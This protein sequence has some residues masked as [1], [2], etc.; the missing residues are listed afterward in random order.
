MS[1]GACE[2]EDYH[3]Y[4][5]DEASGAAELLTTESDQEEELIRTEVDSFSPFILRA[6][7]YT[8]TFHTGGGTIGNL[9]DKE[10]KTGV[11]QTTLTGDELP[12]PEMHDSSV[13][14]AG[15][16]RD[17][18]YSGGSVTSS[19][20]GTFYAKYTRYWDRNSSAY[21][22][23]WYNEKNGTESS[24][25]GVRFNGYINNE[26]EQYQIIA[27]YGYDGMEGFIRNYDPYGGQEFALGEI[28]TVASGDIFAKY[29][30]SY[31]VIKDLYVAQVTTYEG[32][33]T[34]LSYYLWNKGTDKVKLNLGMMESMGL[35]DDH[36]LAVT[37]KTDGLGTY[38]CME[39][40]NL[41]NKLYYKGPYVTDT[42][43]V[44]LDDCD[45]NNYK[46]RPASSFISQKTSQP[47][48]D[49][50]NDTS[51]YLNWIGL[52]IPAGEV[53][54][55]SVLM[56]CNKKDVLQRSNY[57]DLQL[58]GLYGEEYA[59]GTGLQNEQ[60]EYGKEYTLPEAYH[61]DGYTFDGWKTMWEN[62]GRIYQPGEKI[63]AEHDLRT[64]ELRPIYTIIENTAKITIKKDGE[65]WGGHTVELH[66]TQSNLI[67]GMEET[68]PGVYVNNTVVNGTYN[69]WVDGENSQEQITM[70][71]TVLSIEKAASVGYYTAQVETTLD[72]VPHVITEEDVITLRKG[73][74]AKYT[75]NGDGGRYEQILRLTE[76]VQV[77]FNGADTGKVITASDPY[78]AIE[79]VTAEVRILDAEPWRDAAVELH[80]EN[81][82]TVGQLTYAETDP[83]THQ[84]Y[85]REIRKKD[86]QTSYKVFVNQ[87]DTHCTLTASEEGKNVSLV[88]YTATVTLEGDMADAA[89][90]MTNGTENRDLLLQ[91]GGTESHQQYQAEHVLKSED[92]QG[93]EKGYAVTVHGLLDT[94]EG[95]VIT[96]S[97]NS[98]TIEVCT[99]RYL[100]AVSGE[101]DPTEV[102]R[103]YIRKGCLAPEYEEEAAYLAHTF[104]RWSTH[105]WSETDARVGDAFDYTEPIRANVTLYANF[106]KPKLTIGQLLHTDEAGVANGAGQ[107][108]RMGNLTVS[109]FA[110]GEQAIGYIFLVAE[111]ADQIQVTPLDGVSGIKVQ[112]NSEAE[113]DLTETKTIQPAESV[114]IH[115]TTP[116]SMAQ[117]QEFLRKHVI[118][119]PT[120][121]T[122]HSITV[123]L[124]DREGH[125][126]AAN[127]VNATSPS[128]TA[129]ILNTGSSTGKEL[130]SGFYVVTKS[131]DF[132]NSTVGGSGL[133]IKPNA[134][135]YLYVNSGMTLSAT[136]HIG[137]GT[138]GGG[139]G[140]HVP[141]SAKLIL[142]GRGTVVASGGKGGDGAKGG[143]GGDGA[144]NHSAHTLTGGSGGTGGN[145]GG[146]AGAGI[147]TPG[148]TGGSGRG[149]GGNAVTGNYQ[150][151]KT[152]DGNQGQAGG[153]GS[154][155][156]PMGTLYNAGVSIQ[157]HGG[158]KGT[159]G[160][161]G[162]GKEAGYDTFENMF[163]A[164]SAGG[165]GGGGGAGYA[166]A[167]IGTGG[168]GG[169]QG[170]GGGSGAF[171]FQGAS[172]SGL[173]GC[174]GAPDGALGEDSTAWKHPEYGGS[175]EG[176][177]GDHTK[178]KNEPYINTNKRTFGKYA[179]VTSNG[180]EYEV[181]SGGSGL[182]GSS[183]GNANPKS[184]QSLT[185]ADLHSN[186]AGTIRF[187][188]PFDSSLAPQ[189]IPYYPNT[190]DGKCT[191][192]LPAA[193]RKAG[194][195]FLGW[196]VSSYASTAGY[197]GTALTNPDTT[198]YAGG[199]SI[200]L[201]A[202]THGDITMTAVTQSFSGARAEDR[203]SDRINVTSSGTAEPTQ[204]V[205]YYEYQV[206]F[207]KDGVIF[208]PANI[209]I[210]DTAVTPSPDHSYSLMRTSNESLTIKANGRTVGNVEAGRLATIDYSTLTVT[211][212]G[213][214]VQSLV[215]TGEGAPA[216]S[217]QGRDA[218]GNPVY[219]V[220]APNRSLQET[221][222]IRINGVDT[223]VTAAFGRNAVVQYYTQTVQ[224]VQGGNQSTNVQ[225]VKLQAED[226]TALAMAAQEDGSYRLS[227]LTEDRDYTIYVNDETT[228][229]TVRLNADHTIPVTL[230]AYHTTVHVS[231]DGAPSDL[232][233]VHLGTTEM[234]KTSE[235]TYEVT[236]RSGT[237]RDIFV[238]GSKAGQSANG[239]ETEIHYYT[240]TYEHADPSETGTLPVDTSRYLAGSQAVLASPAGLS[241][242]GRTFVGWS[243]NGGDVK[244]AGESIAMTG[245]VRAAAVWTETDLSQA[246]VTL[247]KDRFIYN[248]QTQTPTVTV[249]LDG[250]PLLAGRDYTISYENT[251]DAADR[252]S[253]NAINAGTVTVKVTGI[254]GYRGE[255]TAQ[256]EI[257]KKTI[258]AIGIR[259]QNRVY[260]GTTVIDLDTHEAQLAGAEAGDDVSLM[261]EGAT[262]RVYTPNVG[263]NKLVILEGLDQITG[264]A[265]S[266]YTLQPGR[267][268]YVDITPRQLT[269]DMFHVYGTSEDE[270][271][272]VYSNEQK[273]PDVAASDMLAGSNRLQLD[274]DYTISYG[275]NIHA[276]SGSVAIRQLSSQIIPVL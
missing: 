166:G 136:G 58:S 242:G 139:A 221:Y 39:N 275:E 124:A 105:R 264:S 212:K 152:K 228:N 119:K 226:G 103:L 148:G 82:A 75:P 273:T 195:N 190:A 11:Y 13:R 92:A 261:L 84:T 65:N 87:A 185:N 274:R 222:G 183:G 158:A 32:A 14:F 38:F 17:Q 197:S 271:K 36:G 54:V 194:V 30:D 5:I 100:T 223:G 20:G 43:R 112:K 210:G 207:R 184:A 170:G 241:Y 230:S 47:R 178:A 10:I 157:A 266:N 252:G 49:I 255:A 177:D 128:D 117:A 237:E 189:A 67:Y 218:E 126:E 176:V 165:G 22:V 239:T 94:T 97:E 96:S 268:L 270:T 80:D 116:V 200:T 70:D 175:N 235:G 192:Q 90:T 18:N 2:A 145:G 133:T 40:G 187:E 236:L 138:T 114:T 154:S 46:Y 193:P 48:S 167:D 161:A 199:S 16:Y 110:S 149:E 141:K 256:Y 186:P 122:D 27:Q 244:A 35:G 31:D 267:E 104:V 56:G 215:L 159:A 168:G 89:L 191:V 150:S 147:G 41:I 251:N 272:A 59:F 135:V 229:E 198:R 4:H 211:V 173:G 50:G 248:A 19:Q 85:Y 208:E 53:V 250:V 83:V 209:Q 269:E 140:I 45:P 29:S 55:K 125:F 143:T 130:G 101:T 57:K 61:R 216:L 62:S 180:T 51:V 202:G 78:A 88:Y 144:I 77:F 69:I 28:P 37:T 265:V 146:G 15:W 179:T 204:V 106:E 72:G 137:S 219:G 181:Y 259:A 246:V 86:T 8:F 196:Q 127:T 227:S 234:T 201:A 254:G 276:G 95:V 156:A 169:G 257:T 98:K 160:G 79:Y 108:Y 33:Y 243:I 12:E 206:Q 214:T 121:N 71:S 142:L 113:M 217:E 74:L 203:A 91:A 134:T 225:S 240:L 238:N 68:D 42:D 111:H 171:L 81:G 213:T 73:G 231:V 120:V 60:I 162:S 115:F 93:Q 25:N 153:S 205:Q 9:H 76:T 1:G 258:S 172:A 3:V 233:P 132:T 163:Y 109:G 123:A 99:M 151:D 44:Y 21:G 66:D 24:F 7:L 188:T 220:T 232:G 247:S 245:A 260:D 129:I 107:Y 131:I 182:G 23:N 52:E 262:A 34:R 64:L 6:Q 174:G 102:K 224:I 249:T 164:D 26:N 63:S 155:A 253:A 263:Q 118:V